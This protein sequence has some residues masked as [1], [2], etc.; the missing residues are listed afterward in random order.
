[1]ANAHDDLLICGYPRLAWKMGTDPSIAMI[2]KFTALNNESLLYFQAELVKLEKDLREIQRKNHTPTGN[3]EPEVDPRCSADWQWLGIIEPE[4]EQWQ[5]VLEIRRVLKDYNKALLQQVQLNALQ[6]PTKY[7]LNDIQNRFVESS[8]DASNP[9]GLKG[10]DRLVWGSKHLKK[11]QAKDL[12]AL[13]PR[14]ESDPFSAMIMEKCTPWLYRHLRDLNETVYVSDRTPLRITAMI[15]TVVASLLPIASIA[16]LY[17]NK[18]MKARLALIAIFT[19]LFASALA[20]FST[21]KR[22][23]IFSATA[24]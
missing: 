15:T 3:E 13:S 12:A 14:P 20:C 16:I 19:F 23:E 22:T 11:G 1:M 6:A 21:A 5:T 24:A 7:D 4:C 10:D 2:R 17:N 8:K 18:S 9:I